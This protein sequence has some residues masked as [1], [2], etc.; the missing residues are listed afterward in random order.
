MKP[1]FSARVEDDLPTDVL[2]RLKG[3]LPSVFEMLEGQRKLV[4]IQVPRLFSGHTP[5][6]AQKVILAAEVRFEDGYEH[7]IV[8]IGTPNKVEADFR[9]WE[10]CTKGRMIGSR[11]FSP[12][13]KCQLQDDRVAVVYRD[14]FT[15]FGP[16]D[17]GQPESLEEVVNWA[18]CDDKPDPLSV[19]RAIAHLFTDLGIWFFPGASDQPVGAWK[20]YQS[21]LVKEA[22]K[23]SINVLSKW[24]SDAQRRELRRRVVWVLIGR[25]VPDAD[26]I[27]KPARYLDPVEYVHW[28]MSCEKGK[29]LPSTLVGRSHGDLHARN[30][31]VG[32]RRGEVEYPAVFDYGDMKSTNV[33]AWEFAKL[34]TE[35]KVRLLPQLLREEE[36]FRYLLNR[37]KLRKPNRSTSPGIPTETYQ[38]ADRIVAC[39]A[40]EEL[41]H[42]LTRTIHD[43]ED[44]ER[45]ERLLQ[46]PTG[47]KKLDRL[48]AIILRI[49][50]EASLWLGFKA[51][52]RR[53]L[54]LNELYY[55]LA[56]YGLINV[57]WDYSIPEQ[58]AALVSAGVAVARMP[59]TPMLLNKEFAGTTASDFP[60]F[61]VPLRQMYKLWKNNQDQEGRELAEN[62]V[63]K[64]E[65]HEKGTPKKI[66]VLPEYYHAIPLIGQSILMETE[67]GELKATEEF[68]ESFRELAREFQDY[69]TLARIGRTFKDSGDRKWSGEKSSGEGSPTRAAYLQ[70]Y[71]KAFEVYA[72]AFAVSDDWYVGINA[73]TLAFLTNKNEEYRRLAEAV[74]KLCAD[75]LKQNNPKSRYWLFATEGEA[76][77]L[78]G[79]NE[80]ASKFYSDALDL[81]SEGQCGMADASYKQAVRI[82][83]HLPAEQKRGAEQV[84]ELFEKHDL[85]RF[86]T[87]NFL[88]RPFQSGEQK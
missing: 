62:L 55:A 76:A 71:D 44:A 2:E 11:I 37:S 73:A 58:E 16:D 54:W 20:F 80:Q 10:E 32:V 23:N 8:K 67:A 47:V 26:P 14:A 66:Q 84:L 78:L 30:I 74:A 51:F 46:P 64:V 27:E 25:D 22:G 19:E 57:K 34:E 49:R 50:R 81:L 41:L 45:I 4:S 33:L 7:H 28:A 42:E 86:L 43:G 83:K 59:S 48:A 1:T 82:W 17:K 31:L 87:G 75:D 5:D 52:K 85:A 18:V 70:M 6:F 88:G 36:V 9:G 21:H 29:R 38:S 79:Q 65:R 12:V 15:L 72:E 35:L 77:L 69:E 61:R 24:H 3:E 56:V 39:L 53:D 63:L 60:S 68:L 40:F 13:R